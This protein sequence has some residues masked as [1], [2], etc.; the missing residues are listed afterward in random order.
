MRIFYYIFVE[1]ET[2]KCHLMKFLAR[3]A[4]VVLA[5]ACVCTGYVRMTRATE[6]GASAELQAD[7]D[8]KISH[9]CMTDAD[10]S[11]F[12]MFFRNGQRHDPD[13]EQWRNGALYTILRSYPEQMIEALHMAD[14]AVRH[15]V[16]DEIEAPAASDVDVVAVYCIVMGSD[17]DADVKRCIMDSLA[18]AFVRR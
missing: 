15:N 6:R 2:P 4:V 18:D 1:S 14:E 13:E 7:I 10:C 11:K 9:S 16:Y 5:V 3:Y 12:L 8:S 17:G